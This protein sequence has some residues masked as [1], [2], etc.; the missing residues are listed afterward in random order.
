MAL[1]SLEVEME[2]EVDRRWYGLARR[3]C[4][5]SCVRGVGTAQPCA[6]V[7]RY[8]Y[9]AE[10]MGR[11]MTVGGSGRNIDA[12]NEQSTRKLCLDGHG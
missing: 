1:I 12:T 10:T 6:S 4:L 7:G 11:R 2:V 9:A 8:A 5:G 3:L